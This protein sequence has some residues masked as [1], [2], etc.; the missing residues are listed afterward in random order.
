MKLGPYNVP[1]DSM[2]LTITEISTFTSQKNKRDNNPIK[3]VSSHRSTN[4]LTQR[5]ISDGMY[6]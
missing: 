5:T 6:G 4:K 1:K 2:K 3:Q